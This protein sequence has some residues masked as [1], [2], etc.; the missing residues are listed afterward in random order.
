M[1]LD[2]GDQ[3]RLARLGSESLDCAHADAEVLAQAPARDAGPGGVDRGAT[4]AV[5]VVR[6]TAKIWKRERSRRG[7]GEDVERERRDDL[8]GVH[9][10]LAEEILALDSRQMRTYTRDQRRIERAQAEQIGEAR[11]LARVVQIELMS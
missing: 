2:G 8:E 1:S 9:R 3:G 5:R 11:A 10:E 7:L 4:R 6:E